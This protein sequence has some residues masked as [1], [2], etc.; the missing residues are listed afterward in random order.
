MRFTIAPM[1][2]VVFIQYVRL[3]Y[4]PRVINITFL[5]FRN[6]EAIYYVRD[7]LTSLVKPAQQLN[8]LMAPRE[9]IGINLNADEPDYL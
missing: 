6:F 8:N 2:L 9:T 5:S 4:F 1:H 7:F 3:A